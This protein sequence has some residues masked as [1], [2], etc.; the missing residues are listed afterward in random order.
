MLANMIDKIVSLKQA[1]TFEI[2]G[3]TWA[4]EDLYLV[5]EAN[6][7]PQVIKVSGLD[8]ICKMVRA[9]IDKVDSVLFVCADDYNKV[10]VFTTYQDDF[11]R[12]YLYEAKAD[13]P[14]LGTGWRSKESAVIELRSLCIPNDGVNGLLDM[15]SKITFDDS[16]EIN[17]NGVSQSV[18][19]QSGVSLSTMVN[20]NPRVN[21]KPFRT[22]LEI[23]DQPESEFLFRVDKDKGVG[24]F[25]ADG[26]IWKLEAK[27]SIVTYFE[28]ELSDLVDAGRVIVMA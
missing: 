14:G 1:Q 17:D 19:A 6:P 9:E 7:R 22:F 23:A 28:N 2:N 12:Y 13:A 4:T 8:G 24:L 27:K 20:V 3:K 18:K 21:L 10:S 11:T 25:E 15:L 5:E 26:G 16:L